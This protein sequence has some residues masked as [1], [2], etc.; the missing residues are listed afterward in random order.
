MIGYASHYCNQWSHVPNLVL[1]VLAIYLSLVLSIS[2]YLF[3]FFFFFFLIRF[4]HI[5]SL[6]NIKHLL[7]QISYT[8]RERERE[9]QMI[10][11]WKTGTV[12]DPDEMQTLTQAQTVLFL[13]H[14]VSSASPPHHR[15]C[16][17]AW[18]STTEWPR[19][20]INPKLKLLPSL[21]AAR[22]STTDVDNGDSSSMSRFCW[23][24]N[25]LLSCLYSSI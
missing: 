25:L 7:S 2:L 6:N 8:E 10:F 15:S 24:L 5:H 23:K 20:I 11:F 19:N 1:E 17:L 22:N 9:C 18:Q 4:I 13:K 3:F 14:P 12:A 21:S 16:G